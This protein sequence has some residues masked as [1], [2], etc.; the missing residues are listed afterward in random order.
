MGSVLKMQFDNRTQQLLELEYFAVLFVHDSV[1]NLAVK[2][3]LAMRS[4]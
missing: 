2:G 3:C 1:L 4:G